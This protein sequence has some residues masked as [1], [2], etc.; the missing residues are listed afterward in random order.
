MKLHYAALLLF[1]MPIFH[2]SAQNDTTKIIVDNQEIYLS[3]VIAY[4]IIGTY[5]YDGLTDPIIQ[6][7]A[8]GTGVFQLKDLTKKNIRWGIESNEKGYPIYKEG[9]N[10]AT[11]KLWY[12]N[13]DEID[14][15]WTSTQLSIHY[16]KK[17]IFIAGERSKE[18][19]EEIK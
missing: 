9:F 1:I 14:E 10:S 5:L 17:K 13:N 12:K 16:G 7:N 8:N 4:P 19:Q 11:Y 18:Y 2:S 3:I 6:L 15:N